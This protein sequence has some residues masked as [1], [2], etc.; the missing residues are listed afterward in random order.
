M[1]NYHTARHPRTKVNNAHSLRYEVITRVSEGSKKHLS[2]YADSNILNLV[3]NRID[4][5]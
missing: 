3:G 4:K 2:N 5:V 1:E